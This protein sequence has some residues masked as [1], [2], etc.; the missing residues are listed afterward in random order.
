MVCCLHNL[1]R[2]LGLNWWRNSPR[3]T[4]DSRVPRLSAYA[5]WSQFDGF[6]F[7]LFYNEAQPLASARTSAASVRMSTPA[8]DRIPKKVLLYSDQGGLSTA[9]H[10]S[11]PSVRSHLQSFL[12]RLILA[13]H[14]VLPA[15]NRQRWKPS[16]T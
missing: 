9:Q 16:S 2:F 12:L 10:S 11:I 4:R 1:V 5:R 3:S 15:R 14:E 7:G 8:R 13:F 6:V